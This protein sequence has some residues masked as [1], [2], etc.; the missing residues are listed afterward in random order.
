MP[1]RFLAVVILVCLFSFTGARAEP[2]RQVPGVLHVQ[3]RFDGTGRYDLDQLVALAR[4]RGIEIL[5]PSDHDYQAMEYGVPPFRNLIKKR[6]RRDSVIGIGPEKFLA[7]IARVNAGQKDVLVIPGV[8]SSPFYYWSGIPF[9]D[10][11]TANNYRKEL[12]VVGLGKAADYRNLPVLHGPLSTEYTI[13]LLP[14]VLVLLGVFVLSFY[15]IA[16]R[17]AMH[18]LGIGVAVVSAGLALNHHPFQSSLFD[19][20][21]GD[22]GVR[23][24]QALIDYVNQRGGLVFWLHPESNFGA[25]GEKLGPVRLQTPHYVDD[26]INT[27]DYTGFEA[28]YGDTVRMTDPGKQWDRILNQYCRGERAHPVWGFSGAD[29]HGDRRGEVIDEYQTIF[30]LKEKTSE[31]VLD[32]LK[33]G[34]YYAVRKS[35]PGRIV[36]DTFS[37][38]T[39]KTDATAIMGETLTAAGVTVI[40]GRVSDPNG[41]KYRVRLRLI[42]GGEVFQEMEGD[43][44]IAFDF[45]DTEPRQG[46]T[47]YRLAASGGGRRILSNPI[48]VRKP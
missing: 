37:V 1:H 31:S 46:M 14:R 6:E 32:A 45:H 17:G 11:F 2:W 12:L 34:R 36:L 7:N 20:Y 23:P 40:R 15:L 5:I 43:L 47:Y 27:V 29:F 28:I 16:Q 44:P 18:Y 3:T 24:H 48:F 38:S 4:A 10:D 25:N 19:P 26:L 22:Q 33:K 8:Q 35:P 41:G 9:R 30:L 13:R 21:H 39:T 42:R